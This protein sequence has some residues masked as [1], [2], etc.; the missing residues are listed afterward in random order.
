[1][2]RTVLE[3]VPPL[4]RPWINCESCPI[5]VH[6][7][8]THTGCI[9]CPISLQA[10]ALMDLSWWNYKEKQRGAAKMGRD[11]QSFW[12]RLMPSN[13]IQ[14]P[15]CPALTGPD[16]G[17]SLVPCNCPSSP[18]SGII[19]QC[20]EHILRSKISKFW[21]TRFC[22]QHHVPVVNTPESALPESSDRSVPCWEFLCRLWWWA[23]WTFQ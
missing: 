18:C 3:P 17:S 16:S 21:A 8:T 12:Q 9:R 23:R 6:T 22:L 14:C 19:R 7:S 4:T 13:A 20:C 15:K 2:P 10:Q 5:V 11:A 1:M